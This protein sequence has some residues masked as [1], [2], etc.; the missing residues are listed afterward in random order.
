MSTAA[1]KADTLAA[2][3]IVAAIVLGI[4]LM[5]FRNVGRVVCYGR[6]HGNAVFEL[7]SNATDLA[8]SPFV[9]FGR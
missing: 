9:R 6:S 3:S 4:W 5:T 2:I 1:M 8:A 7:I